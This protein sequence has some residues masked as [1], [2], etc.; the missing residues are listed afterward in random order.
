[1]AC[2]DVLKTKSV[3]SLFQKAGKFTYLPEASMAEFMANAP[4][5]DNIATKPFYP[6][7]ETKTHI[8]EEILP[9][10]GLPL[11]QI[12]KTALLIPVVSDIIPQKA[13]RFW[14]RILLPS[15]SSQMINRGQFLLQQPNGRWIG[16]RPLLNS[17]IFDQKVLYEDFQYG[18]TFDNPREL[19]KGVR[20]AMELDQAH[21]TTKV[22]GIWFNSAGIPYLIHDLNHVLND[23]LD[24]KTWTARDLDSL[25][26]LIRQMRT[27][28]KQETLDIFA[29]EQ[30]GLRTDNG[31]LD[32]RDLEQ[33]LPLR[34]EKDSGGN[35]H[36]SSFKYSLWFFQKFEMG[37]LMRDFG[38]G[39][40][41]TVHD[42]E[43]PYEEKGGLFTLMRL[44]NLLKAPANEGLLY[45]H[46]LKASQPQA[47]IGLTAL[48]KSLGDTEE[49][50]PFQEYL[51]AP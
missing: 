23:R 45:L 48:M 15:Q 49:L 14:E 47:W 2:V 7:H 24:E 1:M 41:V 37:A 20:I 43:I 13:G 39:T 4:A 28:L 11:V 25:E 22:H 31:H 10:E 5:N 19:A 36:L 6:R 40:G 42:G 44:E 30:Q 32:L 12:P 35:I 50:K 17:L 3:E 9:F 51:K 21:L 29:F 38:S 16:A 8:P 46:S 27:Y 26:S 18:A 33:S 34:F